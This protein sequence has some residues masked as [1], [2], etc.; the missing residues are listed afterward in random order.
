MREFWTCLYVMRGDK[1]IFYLMA[2][3]G[4]SGMEFKTNIYLA[5]KTKSHCLTLFNCIYL[6]CKVNVRNIPVWS[7][8]QRGALA[9]RLHE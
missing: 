3:Y 1:K 6:L 4:C 8:E 9:C 5:S 7:A 2:N